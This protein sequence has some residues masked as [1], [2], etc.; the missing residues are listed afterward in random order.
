MSDSVFSTSFVQRHFFAAPPPPAMRRQLIAA[1]FT[2]DGQ[3]WTRTISTVCTLSP[4]E[5]RHFIE[6]DA[7]DYQAAGMAG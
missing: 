3:C 6:Q 5:A 7:K 1:G 4:S 2:F